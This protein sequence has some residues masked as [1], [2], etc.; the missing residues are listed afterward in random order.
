MAVV[1]TGFFD[2]VHLG[3]RKVIEALLLESSRRGEKA[4]VITFW[5]HPR[6]V[7][8]QDARQLRL[9]TSLEEKRE[10]LMG[11]GVDRVEVIPFTR[12]FASMSAVQYL[13]MLRSEFGASCLV[14]GYDTRF[15]SDL[16]APD[17]LPA[18]AAS[19]GIDTITA[20]KL[21]SPE[22]EAGADGLTRATL[23][24]VRGGTACGGVGT[25]DG[26]AVSTSLSRTPAISSTRIRKSLEQGDVESAAAMLGYRYQL[27]GVVVGGNQ[28]GRTIGFPTANLRLYDPLKLIPG[29][30]V[31]QT[32]VQV[33]GKTFRGMTNI[34]VRPTVSSG[35]HVVIETNILDFD[36]MIYGLDLNLTFVRKIRDERRFDSLEAL[37]A[38]L[39]TDRDACAL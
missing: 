28:L 5:P 10:L 22:A 7:L 11:L 27:H 17:S 23:G 30:G 1:A 12:E 8:Q 19:I 14:L 20:E 21:D 37:S 4:V 38:Q 13:E 6:T 26:Q 16:L 9:L 3:H 25:A 35:N 33:L 31:Y 18:V 29:N 32:E 2:G 15:G 24:N 39:R 36:E 34:G